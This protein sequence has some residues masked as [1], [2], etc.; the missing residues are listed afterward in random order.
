MN[1]EQALRELNDYLQSERVIRR[2]LDYCLGLHRRGEKLSVDGGAEE[3]GLLA[4]LLL[5]IADEKRDLNRRLTRLRRKG[6][7]VRRTI[8]DE[9][10][11][12]DRRILADLYLY[13]ERPLSVAAKLNRDGKYFYR[14]R[15]AAIRRYAEAR[16]RGEEKAAA[17]EG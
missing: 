17:K 12:L 10:E 6:E 1:F 13:G 9:T 8:L 5:N 7:T 2:G 4:S 11:G 3:G 16:T 15:N 14:L